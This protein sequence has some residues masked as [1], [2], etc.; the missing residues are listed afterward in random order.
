MPPPADDDDD[1][2]RAAA[3][4]SSAAFGELMRV[5]KCRI[6][7]MAAGYARN[8]HEL[9]DLA[10][11]IFI[12]AW[13]GLPTWQG[14]APFGHW[15]ARVAVRACYDFL[16]RHRQRRAREVSRDA[17]L[18]DGVILAEPEAG[19]ASAEEN[20]ALVRVRC[21]LSRLHPRDQLVLTLL[22]LEDRTVREVAALTGWSESNVKVRAHRAR[23][24]LRRQLETLPPPA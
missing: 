14:A 17:L 10:Q 20:A 22:E 19:T 4:G 12:R 21:A 5:H 23:T 13:R 6:F 18:A 24:R 1:L 8:H 3:A 7:A 16:R 2:A 9:D 15:L 11:D